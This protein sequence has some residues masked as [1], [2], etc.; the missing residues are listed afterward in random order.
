MASMA[1]AEI[2][3]PAVG[4]RRA[5]E[6]RHVRDR[7]ARER[8]LTD[9]RRKQRRRLRLR[10]VL[11]SLLTLALPTST[12]LPPVKHVTRPTVSTTVMSFD[13]ISPEQAYDPFIREASAAY[14]VDAALIR[15]VIQTESAF[16]AMALSR[17]GAGG[18]MQLMPDV[19]DKLGVTDRFDPRENIMGGAR[20]LREL[21][22]QYHGNLPLVLAGYN[23]G[24]AAV[25]RFGSIPPFPETRDYVQ[26]VTRLIKESAT[27][28]D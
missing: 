8:G 9:R 16:D 17:A 28:G 22:D 24:A 20:L 23:A 21:L 4:L 13:P 27:G 7:R 26:R 3:E 2:D 1:P 6:R 5:D 15:S 14:D 12:K 10:S 25:E 19:A 18:L 11:F